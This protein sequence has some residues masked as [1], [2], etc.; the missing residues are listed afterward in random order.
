[1]ICEMI[2]LG[3]LSICPQNIYKLEVSLSN[4]TGQCIVVDTS[5]ERDNTGMGCDKVMEKLNDHYK[6]DFPSEPV[7]NIMLRE[8]DV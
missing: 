4:P 2:V 8:Y 6:A 5:K 3:A 7:E 1:M